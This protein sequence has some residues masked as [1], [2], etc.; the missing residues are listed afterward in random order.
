MA[1]VESNSLNAH[2][3]YLPFFVTKSAKPRVV[4]DGAAVAEGMS[5]YQAVLAGGSL[6]KGL[7]EF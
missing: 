5:N 6:L 7:V 1:A 3:W 4:Y 2:A